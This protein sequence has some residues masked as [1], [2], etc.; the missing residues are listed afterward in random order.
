MNKVSRLQSLESKLKKPGNLSV[1]KN[2]CEAFMNA[3]FRRP[4]F[5]GP[6]VRYTT[7]G[8]VLCDLKEPSG[9]DLGDAWVKRVANGDSTPDDQR[10]VDEMTATLVDVPGMNIMQWIKISAELQDL[11]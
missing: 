6:P 7:G 2:A 10:I 4:E 9:G 1:E 8:M 3:L 5:Q 11:I